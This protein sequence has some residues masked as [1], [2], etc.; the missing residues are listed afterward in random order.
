M[1]I[2]K[3][4]PFLVIS[5]MLVGSIF[6]TSKMTEFL[7]YFLWRIVSGENLVSYLDISLI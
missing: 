5:K 2:Q 4:S 1:N 7:T 3:Q 6:T